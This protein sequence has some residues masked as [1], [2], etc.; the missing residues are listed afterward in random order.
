MHPRNRSIDRLICLVGG[1]DTPAFSVVVAFGIMRLDR[2]VRLRIGENGLDIVD[3]VLLDCEELEPEA[4][5]GGGSGSA[6]VQGSETTG[7]STR[8]R[9][10]AAPSDVAGSRRPSVSSRTSASPRR[11]WVRGQPFATSW[12]P[13]VDGSLIWGSGNRPSCA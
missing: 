8:M 1:L 4:P 10:A 9:R 7:S 5:I 3:A 11:A 2:A 13:R 12:R 6:R